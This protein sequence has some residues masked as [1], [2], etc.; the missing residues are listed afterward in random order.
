MSS[1]GRDPACIAHRRSRLSLAYSSGR[2]ARPS[3][4]GAR[5]GNPDQRRPVLLQVSPT[6]TLLDCLSLAVRH[7]SSTACFELQA[8]LD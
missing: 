6:E 7:P 8:R 5:P 4:A 3:S 1:L 2:D